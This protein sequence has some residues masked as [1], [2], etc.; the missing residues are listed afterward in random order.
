VYYF[1]LGKPAADAEEPNITD[2][3]ELYLI[4]SIHK[5]DEID[6]VT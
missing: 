1:F 6:L 3:V 2:E 5:D 4:D